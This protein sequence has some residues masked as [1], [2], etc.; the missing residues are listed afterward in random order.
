MHNKIKALLLTILIIGS[1]IAIVSAC[2]WY[3]MFIL[4]AIGLSAIIWGCYIVYTTLVGY[5]NH[6]DKNK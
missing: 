2:I 1:F 3:P 4:R 6:Q 5:F